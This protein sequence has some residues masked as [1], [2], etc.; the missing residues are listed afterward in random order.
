MENVCSIRDEREAGEP[1]LFLRFLRF[2]QSL[3]WKT[4]K[5]V[6]LFHG[7]KA[8][9]PPHLQKKKNYLFEKLPSKVVG[10]H[11]FEVCL[12]SHFTPDVSVKVG[13][14]QHQPH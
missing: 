8:V 6:S 2:G 13:S 10:G 11:I 5:G 14:L 7:K 4:Q 3:K 1:P 12:S 9:Y